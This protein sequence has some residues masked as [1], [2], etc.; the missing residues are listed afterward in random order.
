MDE[1]R[2]RGT[3]TLEPLRDLDRLTHFSATNAR[4][5]DVTGLEGCVD[6]EELELWDNDIDSLSVLNGALT[7]LQRVQLDNNDLESLAGLENASKLESLA[8][9]SNKISDITGLLSGATQLRYLYLT[10]NRL[11]DSA[12]ISLFVDDVR[13]PK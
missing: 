8:A 6:L 1:A 3:G 13:C 4:I 7:R 12:L 5:Q 2:L 11:E 9:S 10:D